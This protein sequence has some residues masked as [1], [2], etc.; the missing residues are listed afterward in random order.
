[1]TPSFRLLNRVRPDRAVKQ[2]ENL[3]YPLFS[4]LAL[5]YELHGRSGFRDK[6]CKR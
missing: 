3:F 5:S 2:K 4:V 1:M 6:Q